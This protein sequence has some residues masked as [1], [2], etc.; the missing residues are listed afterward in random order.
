MYVY[1]ATSCLDYFVIGGSGAQLAQDRSTGLQ[2]VRSTMAATVLATNVYGIPTRRETPSSADTFALTARH[3]GRTRQMYLPQ[4]HSQPINAAVENAVSEL[5]ADASRS[6]ATTTVGRYI[7]SS[8]AAVATKATASK[9]CG[10]YG[11]SVNCVNCTMW[12]LSVC[13]V[14][15]FH[16]E[17]SYIGFSKMSILPSRNCEY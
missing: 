1:Y 2:H 14:Y 3:I 10:M 13:L 4:A 16:N 8:T 17:R 9:E 12:A 15:C 7:L 5:V 6:N 11:A